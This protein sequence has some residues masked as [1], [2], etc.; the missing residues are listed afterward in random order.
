[1]SVLQNLTFLKHFIKSPK[2]VGSVIPSSPALSKAMV[3]GV[4]WPNVKTVVEL[5]AGTG[6][7]TAEIEKHRRQDSVFLSFERAP[8]MRAHLHKKFPHVVFKEDAFNLVADIE[9]ELSEKQVD[10]IISALPLTSFSEAKRRQILTEIRSALK[11]H[12]CLVLYQYSGVLEKL[13]RSYFD[14]V[15]VRKVWVNIPPAK[16]FY[17][18]K[19]AEKPSKA[20]S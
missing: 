1:M 6:V 17:C 4:D 11:P 9:N 16:V 19:V 15:T 12:G 7:V 20:I 18:Q 8:K 14:D 5:G 10:C 13:I 2:S 3:D